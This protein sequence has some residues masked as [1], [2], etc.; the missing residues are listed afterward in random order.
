[1]FLSDFV[2][3]VRAEKNLSTPEIQRLTNGEIKDATIS[4]IE[5]N[6]SDPRNVQVRTIEALARGIGE[7][8]VLLFELACGIRSERFNQEEELLDYLKRLPIDRQ[9][10]LLGIAK[11]FSDWE[12]TRVYIGD[13]PVEKKKETRRLKEAKL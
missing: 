6:D 13:Q 11:L 3:K 8:P 4:K 7:S 5:N 10:D 9:R 2:K 1:M 12:K